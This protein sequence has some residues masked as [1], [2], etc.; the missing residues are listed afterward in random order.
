ML[1][2]SGSGIQGQVEA[3]SWEADMVVAV[4]SVKPAEKAP[5]AASLRE[6]RLFIILIVTGMRRICGWASEQG[7]RE[8]RRKKADCKLQ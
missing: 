8:K 1:P 4:G 7:E 5:G 6:P 3:G 2:D